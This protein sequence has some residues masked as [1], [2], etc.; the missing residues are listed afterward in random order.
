MPLVLTHVL[1]SRID[2]F[3]CGVHIGLF[4]IGDDGDGE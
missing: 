4:G 2:V 3:L 1:V